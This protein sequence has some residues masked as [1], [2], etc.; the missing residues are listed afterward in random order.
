[1]GEE[2]KVSQRYFNRILTSYLMVSDSGARSR[3]TPKVYPLEDG[4][5]IL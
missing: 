2:M 4:S 1:M 3:R 5:T